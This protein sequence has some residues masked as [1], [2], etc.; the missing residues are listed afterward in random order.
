M[1]GAHCAVDDGG[2]LQR[3]AQLLATI[4]PLFPLSVQEP[5]PKPSW[6]R[7]QRAHRCAVICIRLVELETNEI[8]ELGAGLIPSVNPR[9]IFKRHKRRRRKQIFLTL[10]LAA[11]HR[12]V[13]DPVTCL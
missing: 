5:A 11:R 7:R 8:R 10:A 12:A 2:L 13:S 3:P 4:K 6:G 9:C 1:C